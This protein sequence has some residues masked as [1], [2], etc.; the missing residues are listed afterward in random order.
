M[1]TGE[2][3][4]LKRATEAKEKTTSAQKDESETLTDYE[5]VLNK[6]ISNLPSNEYTSPYLPDIDKFEK[7]NGT[8]LNTGLVIREKATG[9]EYVWIEVPRTT[10][11]YTDINIT[12]FDETAYKNI[13]N[14]LHT[15]TQVYRKNTDYKDI[16]YEDNTDGWFKNEEEYNA[17]K[18]KMLKSIYQNGGFW[19]GRY[20]AGKVSENETALPVAKKHMYPY[21]TIKRTKAKVLAE[22]VES[23]NYNSSLM[24][25]VQWDLILKYIESKKSAT[26]TELNTNSSTIGNYCDAEFE[27]NGGKFSQ[28]YIEDKWYNFNSNEKSNFVIGCKKLKNNSQG[29][30]TLI[31]TGSTEFTKL[32]NIYDIAGN[33]WEWT[34]EYN[35]LNPSSSCVPRGGSYGYLGKNIASSYR[36]NNSVSEKYR[37]VGFRVSIY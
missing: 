8:D 6:Y 11:I 26:L 1:L 10:N 5:K 21:S 3:G 4:I 24:F 36:S 29:Q 2:N 18:Q 20:E 37:D 12:N 13:E 7:V 16:Y 35:T 31:T 15:Y 9:S 32:Q 14:D 27:L 19:V 28:P 25:G 33:V 23:G 17:L 22:E 34:L 30:G